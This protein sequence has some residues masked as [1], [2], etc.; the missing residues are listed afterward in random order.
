MLSDP[1]ATSRAD[2]IKAQMC[3]WIITNLT[4]SSDSDKCTWPIDLSAVST[5]AGHEGFFE[6]ESYFPPAPPPKTGYHRY[7][8]ALLTAESGA[9][10]KKPKD[11]PHWGYGKVGTGIREWARENELE[12]V[13]KQYQTQFLDSSQLDHLLMYI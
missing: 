5:S 12:V 8:F 9:L 1:D 13:G 4:V 6:I 7:V 11:R 10:P 2:P 3:H